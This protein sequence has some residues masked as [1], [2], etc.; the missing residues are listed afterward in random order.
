MWEQKINIVAQIQNYSAL[1]I[2]II[3]L[4]RTRICGS[5]FSTWVWERVGLYVSNMCICNAIILRFNSIPRSY[6]LPE[7]MRNTG[8]FLLIPLII[9]TITIFM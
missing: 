6:K 9:C 3:I 4:I 5:D 8:K 2:I 1:V 7:N